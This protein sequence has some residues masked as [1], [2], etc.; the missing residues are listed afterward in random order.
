M[1]YERA[2]ALDDLRDNEALGVT[3]DGQDVALA[4]HGEEIFA[5]EDMCSHANVAL[6]EGDYEDCTVECLSLIH[7]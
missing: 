7:I 3:V 4:R 5:V 2:C 1:A 6:S